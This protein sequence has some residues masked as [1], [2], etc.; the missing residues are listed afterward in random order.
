M[1]RAATLLVII[2]SRAH[3]GKTKNVNVEAGSDLPVGK[4][5]RVS[6]LLADMAGSIRL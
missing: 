6:I 1:N 4:K 3:G 2:T 5:K